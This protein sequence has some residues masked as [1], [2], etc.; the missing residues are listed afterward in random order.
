MKS[1][2]RACNG[3]LQ[4]TEAV[5]FGPF[6]P[7]YTDQIHAWSA[8]HAPFHTVSEGEF[9][10]V[11]AAT[12][13]A[14]PNGASL[15]ALFFVH[16]QGHRRAVPK[17]V[18]RLEQKLND[19]TVVLVVGVVA[20]ALNVLLYFGYFL[21]RMTPLIAHINPVGSSLLDGIGKPGPQAGSES[22][23]H[24]TSGK[25]APEGSLASESPSAQDSPSGSPPNTPQDL[26][27]GP[28]PNSSP[29]ASAPQDSPSGSPPGPP[30][31]QASSASPH[32][33]APSQQQSSA[34]AQ[35]SAFAQASASLQASAPPKQQSSAP[36]Q[37][38][39]GSPPPPELPPLPPPPQQQY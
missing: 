37:S 4:S 15:F 32:A 30:P 22:G 13:T 33:S 21:P 6:W 11:R 3:A 5:P 36:P 28:P 29:Q 25:G 7:R 14:L 1:L 35:A 39:S 9:C 27:S 24:Q 26:S 31:P 12:T 38:P 18:S 20:V 16:L 34:S 23:P 17:Q 19:P 2:G 8:A 10:E